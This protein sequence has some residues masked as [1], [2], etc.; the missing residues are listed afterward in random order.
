MLCPCCVR[1]LRSDGNHERHMR[2]HLREPAAALMH[3]ID[4]HSPDPIGV[5]GSRNAARAPNSREL[6]A[7][8]DER[9]AHCARTLRYSSNRPRR[10]RGHDYMWAIDGTLIWMQRPN[11]VYMPVIRP[12]EIGC[13]CGRN[14]QA[15]PDFAQRQRPLGRVLVSAAVP[16]AVCWI[17]AGRHMYYAGATRLSAG[18]GTPSHGWN[19]SGHVQIKHVAAAKWGTLRGVMRCPG[20][21]LTPA[22]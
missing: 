1:V 3:A 12:L 22:V 2:V 8:K 11:R 19:L 16:G 17:A 15:Q 21:V 10:R 18:H 9:N 7:P 4:I 6:G 13:N 14:V 20:A 5:A